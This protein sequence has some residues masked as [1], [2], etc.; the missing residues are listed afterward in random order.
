MLTARQSAMR[1]LAAF[2]DGTAVIN[3]NGIDAALARIAADLSSYYLF[4]YY[5]TNQRLDGRFREITVRVNRPGVRVRARRGDRGLTAEEL[6]GGSLPPGMQP[7]G[8]SAG[9]VA[10][11]ITVDVNP[12]AS[13]RVRTSG[14]TIAT[15]AAPIA[16]VWVVGELDAATRRELAWTAGATADLSVVAATGSEVLSTSVN[17]PA[18]DAGFA[19][20]LPAPDGLAPGEYA[21]RIRVRPNGDGALPVSDTVRM[22][23]AAMPS[24]LGEAVLWRRGVTTGPRFAATADPRFRRG[25]RIRLELPTTGDGSASARMLDRLGRP[26]QVPV[27]VSS[28][29]DPSG[30]FR[31]IVAETPL[32]PLAPGDYAIEVTLGD[33]RQ[34]GAFRVV[35]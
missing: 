15:G 34:V 27:Q 26:M 25:D 31:W 18:T 29:Q 35:P 5:S 30:R 12:R 32:A 11:A 14:W 9:V 28:R 13:F 17:I 8:G 19:L 21:V 3:T 20:Q 16:S 24:A 1:D 23:V 33:A 22:I 6:T 7:L 2:T 10:S 4:S